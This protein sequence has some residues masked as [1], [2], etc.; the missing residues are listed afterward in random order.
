[1]MPH[2]V[3]CKCH[4]FH[5]RLILKP[6]SPRSMSNR[7]FHCSD[8]TC[9]PTRPIYEGKANS[10]SPSTVCRAKNQIKCCQPRQVYFT[11]VL[12]SQTGALTIGEE[13]VAHSVNS[14]CSGCQKLVV[15]PTPSRKEEMGKLWIYLQYISVTLNFLLIFS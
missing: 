3:H 14:V 5:S 10:W 6:N 1:M 8:C 15:L 2:Y 11:Y 13:V 9:I 12:L 7:V 4:H